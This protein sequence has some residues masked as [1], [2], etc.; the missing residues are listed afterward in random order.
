[1]TILHTY[2]TYV[3]TQRE[4]ITRNIDGLVGALA[5]R[6]A[7]VRMDSPRMRLQA[8]NKR[9][10]HIRGGWDARRRIAV[11][12]DDGTAELVHYHASVAAMGA[13][14]RLRRQTR[15]A[16]LPL[17]VHLWNALYRPHP[18]H[19]WAPLAD[20]LIHRIANG[21]IPAS[22]GLAGAD[23]IIVSSRFQARQLQ[24]IGLPQSV[25]VIPNGI[26]LDAYRPPTA[27]ERTEARQALGLNGDPVLAYYGHL[28]SWKGV[29]VLLDALPTVLARVPRAKVLIAHTTYGNSKRALADLLDARGIRDRVHVLGAVHVPTFLHAVDVLAIPSVSAVGT[30]CHP[31]VLLEGLSAG[32]TVVASAVGGNGEALRHGAT[33]LLVPPG[34]PAAWADALVVALGDDDLRRRMGAAARRD[35]EERFDWDL[36]ASRVIDVYRRL[37]AGRHDLRAAPAP[38]PATPS[39]LGVQP[40]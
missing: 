9:S 15:R 16:R 18:S 35:A 28:S 34:D 5:R 24:A 14:S 29:D 12:R 17:L 10:A 37:G 27:E 22:I 6:G 40:A 31:N 8:L 13:W 38:T 39:P 7:A 1:M 25:H 2:A 26:D 4:G 3:S 11:A 20:R 23:S 32:R 36:A 21:P 19:A 30:A 33:G